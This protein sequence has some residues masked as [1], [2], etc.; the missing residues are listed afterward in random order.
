VRM[1]RAG[2]P[3]ANVIAAIE[4]GD[5]MHWKAPVRAIKEAA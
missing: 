5:H 1:L 3:V 2:V 4:A